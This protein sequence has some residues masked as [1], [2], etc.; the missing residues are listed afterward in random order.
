[1]LFHVG[2]LALPIIVAATNFQQTNLTALFSPSL[3]PGAEIFL[4]TNPDDDEDLTQR[5]SL[6]FEPSFVLNIKPA[7]NED[8]Q[9]I[10]KIASES[11]IPFFATGGAHGAELGF[12]TVKNAV[13]IDLGNFNSTELDAAN[14]LL[15]V[16][17]STTF[18][19]FYDLLYN[20]GKEIRT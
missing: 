4:P 5:W 3:S 8:V 20:A 15:T 13:N 14:N 11:H 17:G 9:N 19:Q 1:M 7:T 12:A 6:A 16:G 18:S 2:L 10:V